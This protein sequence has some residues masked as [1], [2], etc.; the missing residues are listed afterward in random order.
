MANSTIIDKIKNEVIKKIISDRDIFEAIDSEYVNDFEE[1]EELIY[2]NVFNYNQVPDEKTGNV[3]YITV[4]V[5]IP[6]NFAKS[7]DEHVFVKPTL[8]IRIV[9]HQRHMPLVINGRCTNRND[10]ISELLDAKLNNQNFAGLGNIR[11]VSNVESSIQE[12]YLG[13]VMVFQTM[14]LNFSMCE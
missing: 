7:D 2:K 10:Y 11:L 14:D 12:N 6:Q 9:S 13:R 5:H 8:E 4:Q 3:T 1:S